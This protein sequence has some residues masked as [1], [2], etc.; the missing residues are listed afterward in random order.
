MLMNRRDARIICL[1]TTCFFLLPAVAAAQGSVTILGLRSATADDEVARNMTAALRDA[2]DAANGEE[3]EHSGRENQ[4]GQLMIA[5]GCD[6]PN[7]RCLGEI[8]ESLASQRLIY[9]IVQAASDDSG[10]FT[11]SLD[12]FDVEAGEVTR[13]LEEP[14]GE[15]VTSGDGAANLAATLFTNLTGVTVF[16]G[17]AVRSTVLGAEVTLDGEP[18]G[19]T[20]SEPL[21]LRGLAP[22]EVNLEVQA[23]DHEGFSETVTIAPGEISEVSVELTPGSDDPDGVD[24]IEPDDVDLATT[25]DRDLPGGNRQG[26]PLLWVGVASIGVGAVLGSLGLWSSLEVNSARSDDES[27][28]RLELA[29]WVAPS[30]GGPD[31]VFSEIE[32]GAQPRGVASRE[33]LLAEYDRAHAF[34]ILQFVFYGTGLA[35]AVVGAILVAR[36]VTAIRADRQDETASSGRRFSLQPMV[37]DGGGAVSAGFSF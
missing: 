7:P 15:E 10:G 17:L 31:D 6:E 14:I 19:T 11:I 1:L 21:V 20:S 27:L 8:G 13:S 30:E 12:Y 22:G 2:A 5:F 28:L 18:V 26:R 4:L 25:S 36:E 35:A 33:D 16:G 23:A 29:Q 9:G 37:L 3:L 24:I 32:G 34:E